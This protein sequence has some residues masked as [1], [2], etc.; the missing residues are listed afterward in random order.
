MLPYFLLL[1]I[2]IVF[3]LFFYQL[4]SFNSVDDENILIERRN[5]MTIILFF[6]GLF[7][8]LALRDIT[9]G[10]DLREYKLIFEK[11]SRSSLNGLSNMAWETGYTIYNK[12][13]SLISKDYRFFLI[14]TALIILVPIYKLY[15]KEEKYSPLLIVLFINMPCFLMI[16]SGLRQAMAFSVGILAY[17]A[18]ENKKYLLSVLLVLLAINFHFSAFV[19]ILLYPAFFLEIKAKHL[20]GIV[21]VLLGVYIFRVPILTFIINLMPKRY[22]EFYGKIELTGAVGMMILF[23]IFS[24][25]SFVVLDE[26]IMSKR[27]YFMRNILLIATVIQLFVPIHELIQRASYYFLIFVPVSIL[28]I[29]QAPKKRWKNVSDTAVIVMGCFFTLYFFYT[30]FFSTDNLLDVFPYKFFWSD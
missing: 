18:I 22:M 17:M 11:C 1:L 13:V 2:S 30:A 15:S 9:V 8:L 23:L 12:L 24:V 26:E 19:L 29:V 10:K 21:P 7:I 28:S 14:I 3:P 16:F 25:F 5:R 27:D 6:V 4:G 20:L